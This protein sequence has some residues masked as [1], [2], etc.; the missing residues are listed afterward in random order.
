MSRLLD[1]GLGEILDRLTI[2]ALK[3]VYGTLRKV[4]TAHWDAEFN[5]LEERLGR[6]VDALLTLAAV[7]ASLWQ[8]EDQIRELRPK[9]TPLPP[10]DP[11]KEAEQI[12]FRI[13]TLN[14]RRAQLVQQI[15]ADAGDPTPAEK[16]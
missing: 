7:N 10:F 6:K 11:V 13:V 4:D 5:G 1:P 3:R 12:A 9:A 2:L 16:I 14:D 8:A 15:N